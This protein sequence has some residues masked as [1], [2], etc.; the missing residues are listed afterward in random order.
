MSNNL[1][2][3]IPFHPAIFFFLLFTQTI[4]IILSSFSSAITPTECSLAYLS[5][6]SSI[7]LLIFISL[8][9]VIIKAGK[10]DEEKKRNKSTTL[11]FSLTV[12]MKSGKNLFITPETLLFPAISLL[13]YYTS[14]K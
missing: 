9:G 2:K 1:E 7:V 14:I 6:Y 12:K 13:V 10:K 8:D 5:P 4:F 11:D 3:F